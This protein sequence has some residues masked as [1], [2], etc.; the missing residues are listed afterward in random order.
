MTKIG[1]VFCLHPT[2]MTVLRR[3]DIQL[4]IIYVGQKAMEISDEISEK[5]GNW[6]NVVHFTIKIKTI[7]CVPLSN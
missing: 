7:P 5:N 1:T 2:V 4:L 6:N 3:E